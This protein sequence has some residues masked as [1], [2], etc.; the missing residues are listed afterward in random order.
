VSKG[1][2]YH[3]I[4]V[5]LNDGEFF[6]AS[7][8]SIY[9]HIT[10]ATV[11]TSYDRDRWDQPMAPDSIIPRILSRELDPDRKVNVIACTEVS[12]ARLRNRAMALALPPRRAR[13]VLPYDK[14]TTRIVDPDLFWI[15]DADE[16]Y[17]DD[18]V[19]RMKE[20]VRTH[21]AST[22]LMWANSYWRSWNWRVH[23]QGHYLTLMR[24]RV[25]F[26]IL[27]HRYPAP[28][29]RVAQKLT[30]EHLVPRDIGFRASGARFI[31]RDVAV[32]HHGNYIGDR[33]RIEA[34]LFSSGHRDPSHERW[35]R[36][37]WDAWTPDTRNFHPLHPENFPSAEWVPTEKLP[38]AIVEHDWPDGWI[39]RS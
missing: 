18:D 14:T 16:V 8:R 27:R 21:S 19:A 36:E 13:R 4:Y 25:W 2:S 31:P 9:P 26:G 6:P 39:D 5:V 23:D 3:A 38:P 7:L 15:V 12:E 10:G 29:A 24:P 20:Y 11:I 35:L 28:F 33:A 32:F 17:D 1:A 34:K 22:Y 30:H 37:V